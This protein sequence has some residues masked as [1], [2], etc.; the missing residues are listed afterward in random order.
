MGFTCGLVGLPNAGKS[1]LFNALTR[2]RQAVVAGYAFS[3]IEPNNAEVPVVDPRLDRVA[4]VAGAGRVIPARLGFTDIAGLVRGASTGEGLGNRFLGHIREVDA[5]AHVLRCF[6]DPERAGAAATPE[7]DWETVTTEL[8]LADLER[9]ERMQ[10]SLA[11][12]LRGGDADA[13]RDT[14]LLDQAL[15]LLGS[16]R[17]ARAATIAA[18]DRP[19]WRRLAFLSARP[20]LLVAGYDGLD[21]DR[22]AL[23]AV[24]ALAARE[25]LRHVEVA[26]A[27]EAEIDSL[28]AE[29]AVEFLR[30]LEIPETGLELLVREGY[31]LLDLVTF[32]TANE[33]EARAWTVPRGTPAVAAA[34]RIHTDFARGFIRAETVHWEEFVRLGGETAVREAGRMRA[35]GRSHVVEDGEVIRFRFHV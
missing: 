2:S 24:A 14:R 18:S 4:G 33:R 25:G 16:G 19:A 17:P 3:T 11:R 23:Q 9:A 26:A 22:D 7:A 20:A 15:A 10:A 30:E 1:T 5:I 34:G 27:V 29:D 8:L 6:P 35:E 32:F 12:R 13:A 21:P 31:A 28:P